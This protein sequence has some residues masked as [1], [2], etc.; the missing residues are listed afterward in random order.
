MTDPVD[1]KLLGE[2]LVPLQYQESTNYLIYLCEL[3][4]YMGEIEDV[5]QTNLLQTDI[6]QAEGVNLDVIGDIVGVA[7]EIPRA[8]PIKFFG[9]FGQTSGDVYGEEGNVSIG[10]RFRN[11]GEDWRSTSVLNDIEYRLLIRAQIVKNHSDGTLD[12]VLEG[13]HY[14]FNTDASVV[15]DVGGMVFNVAIGRKLTHTEQSIIKNLSILPR[16][17]G[18]RIGQLSHFNSVKY[19]GFFHQPGALT[20]GEEGDTSIGGIFSEGF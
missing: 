4:S 16:P 17:A 5:L 15:N 6:D 10:S 2:S 1:H 20:F 8:V 13:L 12:S 18:V 11:E 3:L 7:R 14:L 19:F 9:F